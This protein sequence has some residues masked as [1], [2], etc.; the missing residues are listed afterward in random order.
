MTAQ[1][2]N[3]EAACVF[4]EHR[5]PFLSCVL[6]GTVMFKGNRILDDKD[7]QSLYGHKAQDSDNYLTNFVIEAYLHLISTK[8]MAAGTK[9]KI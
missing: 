1:K 4:P 7:L 2:F 5:Q 6:N 9:V 8:A 3:N